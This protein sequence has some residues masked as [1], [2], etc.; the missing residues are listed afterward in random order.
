M[1]RCRLLTCLLLFC[2]ACFPQTVETV[3]VFVPSQDA[4][5]YVNNAV[6]TW[7][8]GHF[9]C[10]WQSSAVDEDAPDTHVVYSHSRD[11]RHWSVPETLLSCGE[12]YFTSSGGWMPC[13]SDTLVAF[14]NR[15]GDITTGG[16]AH[17]MASSDGMHW[18]EPQPVRMAD[19]SPLQGILEQ[20]P[21]RLPDGR[22]VGAAHFMPGL[23]ARP[24]Y[25]DDPSG[26]TGWRVGRI[27]MEPYGHQSRGIEP[28]LYLRPDGALVMFFRDQASS[29]RK[30]AAVSLDRGESWSDPEL[31]DLTDSRSKQCAGNLPDGRAFYVGNPAAA[32]DRTTLAIAWSGDGMSFCDPVPLRTPDDLPEKMYEGKY[33]TLGYSYPKAFIQDGDLYIAYSE[34]KERIALTILHKSFFP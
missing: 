16:T 5:H 29:F 28:S 2:T 17:W 23:Q 33:K 27:K 31:T 26:R 6:V 19:G 1:M 14:V 12:R 8:R 13:G 18:S 10:M 34:N 11:A 22:L 15:L 4:D 30:L 24:I 7:F 9:Y 25:T 3:T 21:H 32:K 20:D